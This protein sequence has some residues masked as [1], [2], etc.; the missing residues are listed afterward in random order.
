MPRSKSNSSPAIRAPF[1]PIK[2]LFEVPGALY[3]IKWL[4]SQDDV[5]RIGPLI[6]SIIKITQADPEAW[7]KLTTKLQEVV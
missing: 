2:N 4:A 1:E 3:E 5:E 6:D 7:I